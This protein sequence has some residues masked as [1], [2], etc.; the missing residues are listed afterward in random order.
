[1][2]KAGTPMD[3]KLTSVTD[4]LDSPIGKVGDNWTKVFGEKSLRGTRE[5]T[6]IT[7]LVKAGS[8]V[9]RRDMA[10]MDFLG[11]QVALGKRT[12]TVFGMPKT[13]EQQMLTFS[14]TTPVR[15]IRL[16]DIKAIDVA[17]QKTPPAPAGMVPMTPSQQR[18]RI[19]GSRRGVYARIK[20]PGNDYGKLAKAFSTKLSVGK[21]VAGTGSFEAVARKMSFEQPVGRFSHKAALAS[22]SV[23]NTG[24]HGLSLGKASVGISPA[25]FEAASVA[26]CKGTVIDMKDIAKGVDLS[27][28]T[29]RGKGRRKK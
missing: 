23:G 15:G 25:R 13:S 3:V 21:Q 24:A 5:G 10:G 6:T 9:R 22:I 4:I 17:V 12:S 18:V 26:Q 2:Q 28:I 1:M 29:K 27:K 7:D 19:K 14:M 11:E 20:V 8:G 16:G